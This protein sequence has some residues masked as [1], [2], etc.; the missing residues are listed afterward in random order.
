MPTDLCTGLR[1]DKH[2]SMVHEMRHATTVSLGREPHGTLGEANG[3][4]DLAHVTSW[5][6]HGSLGEVTWARYMVNQLRHKV[7]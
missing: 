6:T 1:A 2:E 3:T 7:S 4:S 5:E